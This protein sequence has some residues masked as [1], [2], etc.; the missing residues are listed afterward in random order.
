MIWILALLIA[1]VLAILY[2]VYLMIK[3]TVL[4]II[5]FIYFLLPSSEPSLGQYD[6]ATDKVKW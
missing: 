6:P 4:L 5:G 3:F 2:V 1:P